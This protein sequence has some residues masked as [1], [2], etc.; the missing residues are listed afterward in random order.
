MQS[1]L[2]S[3]T[4]KPDYD[5]GLYYTVYNGPPNTIMG[6]YQLSKMYTERE[7]IAAVKRCERFIKYINNPNEDIICAHIETHGTLFY[8][9][10]N[11]VSRNVAM[12]IIKNRVHKFDEYN[13]IYRFTD[14]EIN[15]MCSTNPYMLKYVKNQTFDL[16]VKMI[17]KIVRANDSS[18][19]TEL[20]YG[21]S[22]IWH[23]SIE[24]EFAECINCGVLTREEIHK[25]YDILYSLNTGCIRY[26]NPKFI[27]KEMLCKHI[28]ENK[29]SYYFLAGINLKDTILTKEEKTQIYEQAFA[30]SFANFE[31]I[32]P[33]YQT[34]E[35]I[36]K[37]IGQY[38]KY[39]GSKKFEDANF[40]K[41][42][43]QEICN[44]AFAS[45][46]T[47]FGY[48]NHE[49]QTDDMMKQVLE[50]TS[51]DAVSLYKHI[52][53]KNLITNEIY[54]A[55]FD[56]DANCFQYIPD[57]FK[58]SDMCKS[59]I[60]Q[61]LSNIAFVPPQLQTHEMCVMVANDHYEFIKYCEYINIDML[62]NVQRQRVSESKRKR[63]DF[64]NELKEHQLVQVMKL[65]PRLIRALQH[66]NM[67]PKV[68]VAALETNGY[69]IEYV[70][71]H[72]LTDVYI[73]IAL[74]QQ[75]LAKKYIE[76]R[77][78]KS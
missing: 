29:N 8:E 10:P 30:K 45:S 72:M 19:Y 58:T 77:N 32:E 14:E 36:Y 69:V 22:G 21:G 53:N 47:N 6:K 66:H 59:A 15:D 7:L 56:R 3:I 73:D 46:I 44:R 2:T 42:E 78:I 55:A 16:C 64:I 43:K 54:K 26:M 39:L 17:N 23:K 57:D 27:K 60:N 31:Y 4:L 67:T 11:P 48:I 35:M 18:H 38:P 49:Y 40:T 20:F 37:Y 63:Y 50:C 33:E 74:K 68:I 76:N 9:P 51:I 65:M 70:P 13:K 5:N 12:A 34:K 52:K 28:E 62:E 1:P 24:A 61:S 71:T 25:L 41:E 75:P